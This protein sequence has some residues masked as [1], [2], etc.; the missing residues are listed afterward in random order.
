M[1]TIAARAHSGVSLSAPAI[2]RPAKPSHSARSKPGVLGRLG[3]L[4][5]HKPGRALV[6]LLFVAVSGAI[7]TNAL[8][9]QK[10]RHPA[11]MISAPSAPA[12]ARHAVRSEQPA[13]QSAPL[14]TGPTS[15]P[16]PGGAAPIPPTRP[17]ELAQPAREALP[18]ETAPRPPAP[19]TTAARP[20]PTSTPAPAARAPVPARDPIADLINGADMRPPADIR[21]VAQARP[22]QPRRSVEN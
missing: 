20:V 18:R 15:A 2:R 1:S 13:V 14:Q 11:P 6:I 12:P 17:A 21:P 4:A 22:T 19:V 3:R 7:L 10:A 16:A 9:F 8:F 5:L